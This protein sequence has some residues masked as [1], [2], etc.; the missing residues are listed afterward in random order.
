MQKSGAQRSPPLVPS[1]GQAQSGFQ[2]FWLVHLLSRLFSKDPAERAAP[3]TSYFLRPN[4]LNT[5]QRAS[6]HTVL[7][8]IVRRFI[9][10]MTF[11][12]SEAL[13]KTDCF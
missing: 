2:S 9:V 1:Q 10:L 11:V 13:L 3:N 8:E 7:C 6:V 12:F 4:D 5:S